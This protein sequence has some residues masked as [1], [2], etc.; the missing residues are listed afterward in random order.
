MIPSK[1]H[2]RHFRLHTCTWPAFFSQ[3]SRSLLITRNQA[4]LHVI[5]E[6]R[7]QRQRCPPS[8]DTDIPTSLGK[9]HSPSSRATRRTYRRWHAPAEPPHGAP[10][11]ATH[12]APPPLHIPTRRTGVPPYRHSPLSGGVDRPTPWR[13]ARRRR[14]GSGSDRGRSS[15]CRIHNFLP[16]THSPTGC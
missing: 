5:A 2:F 11:V 9:W 3:F 6:R 8:P 4:Q 14:H 13:H 16:A 7:R 10:A 15:L 12:H 1:R